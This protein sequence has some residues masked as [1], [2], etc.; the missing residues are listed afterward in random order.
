MIF[1]ADWIIDIKNQ[2]DGKN[3]ANLT[4]ERS[5]SETVKNYE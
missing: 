2:D 3:I 1:D 4:L 5:P